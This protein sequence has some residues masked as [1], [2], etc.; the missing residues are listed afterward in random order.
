MADK[1]KL[2]EEMRHTINQ[3]GGGALEIAENEITSK[4]ASDDD[5]CLALKYFAKVTL[6]NALPVFPALI[7]ISCEAVG[8]NPD[9][10]ES[11][12]GAITLIAGAADLHDDVI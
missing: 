5:V 3:S 2:V 1:S 6:R 10:T 12:G 8:G 11:I 7:S 4:F 9:N